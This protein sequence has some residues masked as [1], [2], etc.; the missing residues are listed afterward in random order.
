M[1]LDTSSVRAIEVILGLVKR[2]KLS[3][4]QAKELIAELVSYNVFTQITI[5]S[6]N[7]LNYT[8]TVNGTSNIYST[9]VSTITGTNTNLNP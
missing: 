4:E 5:S 8:H 9:L 7:P 6:P 3:P 2:N 1:E